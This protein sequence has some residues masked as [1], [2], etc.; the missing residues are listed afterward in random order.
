MPPSSIE[1]LVVGAERDGTTTVNLGAL[2]IVY[3]DG[4]GRERA[5]V[6][7]TPPR[8]IPQGENG[9]NDRFGVA[10]TNLGDLDGDGALELAVG[11]P[12]TGTTFSEMGKVWVLSLEADGDIRSQHA[13]TQGESGFNEIVE[14]LDHFG[15]S[16]AA[17]DDLDGDGVGELAV[18]ASNDVVLEQTG[19]VRVLFL[20]PDATVKSVT[21]IAPGVGGFTGDADA[22]DE[23]GSALA[24]IGDLDGDGVG[25]L[26]VGASSGSVEGFLNPP[27]TVWI[28]FLNPDGTVRDQPPQHLSMPL[29]AGGSVF[30]DFEVTPDSARV[31]FKAQAAT[32]AR[33]E[34]YSVPADGSQAPLR[35]HPEHLFVGGIGSSVL[36]PSGERVVYIEYEDATGLVGL[37]SV[38]VDGSEAPLEIAPREA[39]PVDI[40]ELRLRG[41]SDFSAS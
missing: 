35:L 27:G 25:D 16:L 34:L 41:N 32:L 4:E 24:A 40:E 9:I 23:F 1:D 39:N 8:P 14:D 17:L 19:S 11:A 6:H 5:W 20:N 13:I 28:L 37:F 29:G 33:S 36:Q 22:F 18:G 15:C 12:S 2:W 38:P 31:V 26:A 30:Q 21:T 7:L 10:L 3:L